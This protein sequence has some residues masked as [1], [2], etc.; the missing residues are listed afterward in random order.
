MAQSLG[1][2]TSVAVA[3]CTGVGGI[4]S[5]LTSGSSYNCGIAVDMIQSGDGFGLGFTTNSTG[6]SLHTLSLLGG[7]SGDNTIIPFM[8]QSIDIIV[9]IAMFAVAGVSSVATLGAGGL[10]HDRLVRVFMRHN[11][12]IRLIGLGLN[13]LS[14]DHQS[15]GMGAD[16]LAVHI[17]SDHSILA[18]SSG[19]GLGPV[20]LITLGNACVINSQGAFCVNQSI[21]VLGNSNVDGI[22]FAILDGNVIKV[23]IHG[24]GHVSDGTQDGQSEVNHVVVNLVAQVSH[25]AVKTVGQALHQAGDGIIL[26][27]LQNQSTVGADT[28]NNVTDQSLSI[29][30]LAAV[31]INSG[32]EVETGHQVAGVNAVL[33]GVDELQISSLHVGIDDQNAGIH[34]GIMVGIGH[35]TDYQIQA[36][37]LAVCIVVEGQDG[38]LGQLLEHFDQLVKGSQIHLHFSSGSQLGDLAFHL[39]DGGNKFAHGQ[40]VV[41]QAILSNE[42]IGPLGQIHI[43]LAIN[44][45][46]Q[47]LLAI[48]LDLSSNDGGIHAHGGSLGRCLDIQSFLH[49]DAL[50][51]V[52][53]HP[54]AD[55]DLRLGGSDDQQAG[56]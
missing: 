38:L 1:L 42:L 6:V 16:V 52:L 19:G 18:H 2:I 45:V 29:S 31:D 15:T 12:H 37:I 41:H 43:H 53:D 22:I 13:I 34:G 40:F 50:A 10:G 23:H 8:A 36:N 27:T 54:V 9:D 56:G 17:D 28:H 14:L 51:V 7:L 4:T 48:V 33:V 30:I 25:L 32:G 39:L 49:V 55:N 35:D 47:V 26:N 44:G 21:T 20:G 24:A 3:A 46:Q 11:G 5:I